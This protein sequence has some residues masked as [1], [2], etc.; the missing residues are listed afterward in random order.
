MIGGE[1]T[2][3]MRTAPLGSSHAH[4][5][6]NLVREIPKRVL[7]FELVKLLEIYLEPLVGQFSLL[8]LSF[9][10]SQGAMDR[11]MVG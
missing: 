8:E 10:S 4:K 2:L 9:E 7:D 11:T 3:S 6:E 1:C 5:A